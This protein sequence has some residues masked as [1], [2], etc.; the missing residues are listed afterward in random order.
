MISRLLADIL[1][2]RLGQSPAV[3]LLGSRQVGK[4]TLARAMDLGKPIHYLDLERPSD[5]AKLADPELYLSGFG[6]RLVILD[7]VQRL[8]GLFPVLRSLIDERRRAGEKVGQFLLLGSASPALLQQSSET[9]AGR[10]SYLE[11]TPFQLMEL[12]EPERALP[13]HWE[14]GGYPDS[15]LAEDAASSV[16]WREDFITSYVERFLPQQ[17]ITASPLLLRRFCSMLAHQ[18]GATINLSKLGGSLGIDAKTAR[19]YID[20]LEGLYLVRSLPPWSRNVGKRLVKSAKVYWRDSGILHTL[21]G[22]ADLEHVLGHPLC[23]A[24]WEGYCIEQ[25]LNRLPKGCVAS[26]YRTQAGAEVDL[27]IESPD[28]RISAVEIK[29]TLSPKVTSGLLESME[30]LRADCAIMVIPQGD[31]YPLS[32]SV[33]ATGLI[34]FLQ[35]IISQVMHGASPRGIT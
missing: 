22:L 35:T 5:L 26:H 23:G 18:Q 15:Y 11:L 10:I 21:A 33:T 29:R 32:K 31:A 24:S 30:T 4:T 3:A 28:G 25:I 14:R 17:N 2:Q 1:L 19:R 13:N 6:D 34:P 9:L 27:V 8:P 12:A 16:Q 20:L 7:E